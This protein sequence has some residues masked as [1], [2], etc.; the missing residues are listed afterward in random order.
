MM[1][2]GKCLNKTFIVLLIFILNSV[3]VTLAWS[4]NL[5]DDEYEA[6]MKQSWH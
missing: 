2:F 4:D 1:F 5:C 3:S 6:F